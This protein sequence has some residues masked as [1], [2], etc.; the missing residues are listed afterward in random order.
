MQ[1]TGP[2]LAA[3]AVLARVLARGFAAAADEP[4]LMS[5]GSGWSFRGLAEASDALAANLLDL[6]LAP[7]DRV[8]SLMP[9]SPELVLHYLGCLKAGLVATPLNYRYAVPEIDHALATAGASVLIAAAERHND[10]EQS[11]VVPRLPLGVIWYGDAAPGARR[12]SE[13]FTRSPTR[14]LPAPDP[15]TP[16]F[17]F[18]TSGSTGLPKGVTHTHRT[19]GWMVASCAAA[20]ELEPA[21]VVLPA[22]SLSH[23]AAIIVSLATLSVGGWVVVPRRIEDDELL[24]LLRAHRPAVLMMLPAALLSLVRDQAAQPAD[25]TSVRVCICGGDKVSAELEHEYQRL[26]GRMVDEVYGMTEIGFTTRSPIA[27]PMREGSVGIPCPGFTCALR[28]EDGRE[29]GLGEDGRLWVKSPTNMVAY[30]NAPEA[31]AEVLRDG[32]LDTGDVMRADADGY[33]WFRS[34][35]KQLIIH[36][37]SNIAPQEV[38]E[39]LLEHPAVALAG[40]IGIHDALHGENVRAYVALRDQTTRPTA[41]ELRQFARVRIAAYKVPEDIVF[42]DAIPLTPVGKVDRGAL[43]RLAEDALHAR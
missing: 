29:V 10:V 6:G 38:E 16:A 21:E 37:G 13:L 8:A 15:D 23:I 5:L 12:L 18:F 30:W 36:D 35:K 41:Q 28:A 34:R 2:P 33:L 26:A 31:T 32:W 25:F 43:K 42:M 39:A 11:A 17:V 1:L 4:A 7:G 19:F 3:P 20:L 27:G 40:V 9:N 24:P 14:A 22:T